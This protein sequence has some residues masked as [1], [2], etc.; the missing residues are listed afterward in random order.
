[1][2]PETAEPGDERHRHL[3]DLMSPM[4]ATLEKLKRI[5]SG[6]SWQYPVKGMEI[7]STKGNTKLPLNK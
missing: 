6:Y 7:T 4:S 1:M 2:R 3:T 5:E